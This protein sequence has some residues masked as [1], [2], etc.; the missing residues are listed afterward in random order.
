MGGI[1]IKVPNDLDVECDGLAVLGGV[2]MLGKSTGG[3]IASATVR[4][5]PAVATNKKLVFHGKAIM[6]GIE[7]KASS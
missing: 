1:E 2:E 3:I 6:G 5:T 4:Q 7:I